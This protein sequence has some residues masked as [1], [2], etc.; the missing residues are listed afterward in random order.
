MQE[1]T[2][3]VL[4]FPELWQRQRPC[5]G[6]DGFS[7]GQLVET[8]HWKSPRGLRNGC[9]ELPAVPKWAT[10]VKMLSNSTW[11]DRKLEWP[12]PG[13]LA[14][15]GN[16]STASSRAPVWLREDKDAP[17]MHEIKFLP[18]WWTGTEQDLFHLE[19][20]SCGYVWEGC[21]NGWVVVIVLFCLFTTRM[22]LRYKEILYN[23]PLCC[24]V[25]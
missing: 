22:V 19:K 21:W 25:N 3:G 23:A 10:P 18:T 24:R 4:R 7:A 6:G 1:A 20:Q 9:S 2:V 13:S 8:G 15:L 17:N 12:H 5:L 16:P 11:C 14:L